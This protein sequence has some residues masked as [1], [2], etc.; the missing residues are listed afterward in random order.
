MKINQNTYIPAQNI[1]NK[2]IKK[3][4]NG[5]MPKDTLLA[6]QTSEKPDFLKLGDVAKESG[7]KKTDFSNIDTKLVPY[8]IG[9]G[10][11]AASMACASSLS[12]TAT[13]C[14]AGVG[15]LVGRSVARRSPE[16]AKK[17]LLGGTIGGAIGLAI[18]G[19]SPIPLAMGAFGA[20]MGAVV[21]T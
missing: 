9:G 15:A 10:V 2:N 18:A 13:L 17:A 19:G 21:N 5:V 6:E 1:K 7:S 11:L 8:I 14:T 16:T 12:L 4:E 20:Y 3:D